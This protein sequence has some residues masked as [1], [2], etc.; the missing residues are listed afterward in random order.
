MDDYMLMKHLEKEG[1]GNHSEQEMVDKF[2]TFLR[3]GR[4]MYHQDHDDIYDMIGDNKY[5]KM[6]THSGELDM[7]T[8]KEIVQGMYHKDSGKKYVGEK[9]NMTKA[10]EVFNQYVNVLPGHITEEEV[11]IAINAQYHDYCKLFKMWFGSNV[12]SKIIESAMVFWFNDDDYADES[13]V[14]KYFE[15]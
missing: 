12:E 10:K 4:R 3:R 2:R 9:F 6:Y 7:H 8:A 15:I 11:Y 13:K 1:Y 14:K 5:R